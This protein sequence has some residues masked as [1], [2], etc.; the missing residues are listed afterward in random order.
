MKYNDDHLDPEIL[1]SMLAY[2][3]MVIQPKLNAQAAQLVKEQAGLS[4]TQWRIAALV[5]MYGPEV[6]S[7]DILRDVKM[8]K[9]MFSRSLKSLIDQGIITR[10]A[11]ENDQ[12]RTLLSLT[13]A[14][15][16]IYKRTLPYIHA[17]ERHL[18]HDFTEEEQACLDSVLTKL[19][20]NSE[21]RKFNV[22]IE[23]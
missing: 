11:D 13:A 15:E 7:T 4:L 18:V 9:G 21:F 20:R 10:R 2:R 23:A 17:R 8:D 19:E 22:G 16:T 1:R 6:A 12:R 5:K 3:F 14:G